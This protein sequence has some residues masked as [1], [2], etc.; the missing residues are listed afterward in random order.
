MLKMHTLNHLVIASTW[1]TEGVGNLFNGLCSLN[2][3]VYIRI[4]WRR[5][6]LLY[7]VDG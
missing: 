7:I 5:R 4:T 2:N 3:H 6:N 1:M